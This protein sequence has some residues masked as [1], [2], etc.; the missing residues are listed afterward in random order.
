MDAWEPD[1]CVE[2]FMMHWDAFLLIT[3]CQNEISGGKSEPYWKGMEH[4]WKYQKHRKGCEQEPDCPLRE[5]SPYSSRLVEGPL[6]YALSNDRITC[7]V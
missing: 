6:R 3:E 2:I 7:L 1:S 5:S 4:Y